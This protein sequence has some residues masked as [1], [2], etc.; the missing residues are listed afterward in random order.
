MEPIGEKQA[1]NMTLTGL[2]EARAPCFNNTKS[3]SHNILGLHDSEDVDQFS[4]WINF[5]TET[6]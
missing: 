1:P 6:R 4:Y 2:Q 5:Q 3:V